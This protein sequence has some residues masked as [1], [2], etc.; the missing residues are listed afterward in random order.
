METGRTFVDKIGKRFREAFGERLGELRT[1]AG[2]TQEKLAEKL[3]CRAAMVGRWERGEHFPRIEVLLRLRR[4]L[5]V[6]LD[7]LVTG[8]PA[9]GL[10]DIRLLALLQRL[11]SLPPHRIEEVV[12]ILEAFLGGKAEPPARAARGAR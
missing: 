11:D 1:A 7:Y 10:R 9:S 2:F 6:S 4:E 5:N 8:L 3:G 12:R